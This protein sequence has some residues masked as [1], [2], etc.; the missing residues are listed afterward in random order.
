MPLYRVSLNGVPRWYYLRTRFPFPGRIALQQPETTRHME[1]VGSSR[2]YLEPR[3]NTLFK[4]IADKFTAKRQP[5]NW[6][7]RDILEKRLLG[8]FDA[9]KEWRSNRLIRR[10]GLKAVACRG[11]GLAINPL[12]PLGSLLAMEYLASGESGETHFLRLDETA[13]LAFIR[14]LCDDAAV[15]IHHGYCHRDFH[16]GNVWVDAKGDIVWIDTHVKRLPRRA[17]RRRQTIDAMLSPSKLKGDRYRRFAHGYLHERL[18]RP[19]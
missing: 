8:G 18:G 11:V 14:R 6:W 3:S 7:L 4:L 16:Y 2:F 15:L 13:R 12:N 9:L 1:A 17:D 10:A 5:L 19:A